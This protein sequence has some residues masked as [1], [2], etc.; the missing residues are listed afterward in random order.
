M[1]CSV[2]VS[3]FCTATF[4]KRPVTESGPITTAI[5]S[6]TAEA[7]PHFWEL[8]E[9]NPLSGVML[10]VLSEE[11]DAGLVLCKSQFNTLATLS[12]SNNRFAA[13]W[14]ASAQVIQKL[15]Q[16]HRFGWEHLERHA[17]PPATYKGKYKIYRSP[18]NTQVA[19]W[20]GPVL[21]KKA[22][23]YYF[24]RNRIDYWRI[25]LRRGQP[26]LFQSGSTD[27]FQWLT[28]PKGTILG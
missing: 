9:H 18:T 7:P 19:R 22:A 24:R 21:L 6:F 11:L 4:L 12:A 5:T 14:G 16:L 2:S 10:Q 13:Y 15:N 8:V 28:S 3:T 27:Q 20:L 26:A 1:C 25:G 17:V 23:S